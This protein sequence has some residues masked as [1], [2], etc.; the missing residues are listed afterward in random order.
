M[1]TPNKERKIA[2]VGSRTVGKSSLAVQFV[3]HHFVDHYYPTIEN[4]FNKSVQ[5]N[6]RGQDEFSIIS[7]KLLIGIHGYILIYSITNRQSFEMIRLIRDKILDTLEIDRPMII[8]GNKSDLNLQRQVSYE[9]LKE[10]GKEFGG[11]PV[12]ECSAKS[13]YNVDTVFESIVKEIEKFEGGGEE[14]KREEGGCAIS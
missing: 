10:L 5:Y 13:N 6:G 9:E 14:E 2:I 11:V 12:M 8:V 3:D 7:N 1:S 4:E